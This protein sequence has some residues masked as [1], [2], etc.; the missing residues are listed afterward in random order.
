MGGTRVV[1]VTKSDLFQISFARSAAGCR[2]SPSFFCPNVPKW[3]M[4]NFLSG[5]IEWSP[6]EISVILYYNMVGVF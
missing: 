1:S 3:F 2:G 4:C 6:I 5:F